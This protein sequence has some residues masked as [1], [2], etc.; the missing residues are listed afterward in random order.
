MGS[1]RVSHMYRV[2]TVRLCTVQRGRMLRMTSQ[3]HTLGD[4]TRSSQINIP[5]HLLERGLLPPPPTPALTTKRSTRVADH[6][7]AWGPTPRTCTG[8]SARARLVRPERFPP[9]RRSRDQ[10]TGSQYGVRSALE[11]PP[12]VISCQV[13]GQGTAGACNFEH[14]PA[15]FSLEGTAGILRQASA[16]LGY[17]PI[18]LGQAAKTLGMSP[19]S[20]SHHTTLRASAAHVVRSCQAAASRL[21]RLAAECCELRGASCERAARCAHYNHGCRRPQTG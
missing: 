2:S 3:R 21:R 12:P 11:Y 1:R 13:S 17:G 6:T 20:P 7:S 18:R 5:A 16:V 19:L 8:H 9:C 15:A 10:L 14:Q 4:H